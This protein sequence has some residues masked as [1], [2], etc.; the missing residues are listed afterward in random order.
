MAK[1]LKALQCECY[2]SFPKVLWKIFCFILKFLCL[3]FGIIF[4]KF[5]W[6]FNT[7]FL[8]FSE[9]IFWNVPVLLAASWQNLNFFRFKLWFWQSKL[10]WRFHPGIWFKYLLILLRVRL[11]LIISIKVFRSFIIIFREESNF[12]I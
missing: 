1:I 3:G 9:L 5:F 12:R 6:C 11:G 10:I 7:T 8:P 4:N 2:D